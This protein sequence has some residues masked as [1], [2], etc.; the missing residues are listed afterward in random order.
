LPDRRFCRDYRDHRHLE[1]CNRIICGIAAMARNEK[2]PA[3]Y[4]TA[5]VLGSFMVGNSLA[6]LIL[7]FI[8]HDFIPR[9]WPA[10][11]SAGKSTHEVFRYVRPGE[12]AIV[13]TRRL[14]S[15][16]RITRWM[17]S[18]R[19]CPPSQLSPSV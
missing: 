7:A 12:S 10:R 17:R 19:G 15:G 11:K 8:D 18:L 4:I 16:E 13:I 2:R 14:E 3:I 9:H 1:R 6:P 5:G